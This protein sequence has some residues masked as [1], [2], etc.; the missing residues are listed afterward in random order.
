MSYAIPIL[1]RNGKPQKYGS[2]FEQMYDLELKGNLQIPQ[3]PVI[4]YDTGKKYTLYDNTGG[5]YN[6]AKLFENND[7]PNEEQ[8]TT[9]QQA[10]ERL[11]N[12]ASVNRQLT[13]QEKRFNLYT[14]NNFDIRFRKQLVDEATKTGS[15]IFSEFSQDHV[16]AV[17]T[18]NQ[19]YIKEETLY[20]RPPKGSKEE[21]LQALLGGYGLNPLSAGLA[22]LTAMAKQEQ[23]QQMEGQAFRDAFTG[24]TKPT[25]T[26]VFREKTKGRQTYQPQ[27][28]E[29]PKPTQVQAETVRQGPQPKP[30]SNPWKP[31]RTSKYMDVDWFV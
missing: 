25:M 13:E 16:N 9:D 18:A 31:T 21:K 19:N 20:T 5:I 11:R 23:K 30:T 3:D 26:D 4:D 8:Q 28:T 1:G 22:G 29:Q 14:D 24:K 6:Q 12:N 27:P 7:D 10:M 17:Q 15:N 2:E